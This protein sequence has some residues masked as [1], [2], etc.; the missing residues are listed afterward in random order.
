[1][2]GWR[3]KLIARIAALGAAT[4]ALSA[5]YYDAGAGLGYYDD[6]YDYGGYDYGQ[7]ITN[8]GV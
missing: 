1:M 3:G 2:A 6:G 4:M 8:I 5:C 7:V